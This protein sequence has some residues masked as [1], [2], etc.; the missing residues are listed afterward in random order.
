LKKIIL[1]YDRGEY[2]KVVTLARRTLFD[3]DYDK[4]EEIPIRT[5][6]AFS[7]VALERNEEAKDVFLQ[8]LSMAPDYYLDPDFVSPK[9]IQ[10]FREAQKEYFASLKEKEE[11]EPIPPPSW[12]DY[13][14]PGRYQKNYGNK[15]R[16]EFLRTGAVIS[17]GGLALSHLLYLYTHNLY[18]SKKDPEEVIRYYNYYNYS[19]KT[20]RFFF[21]L[22]LLFWM[23]NAFDLL[24][25]GK[26]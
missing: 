13:L 25:G 14:I 2:G 12:K 8:I 10:V 7:L 18:L 4:G 6:L 9:I 26:E 17:A 24:T 11:K 5:Y 1:L 21:D 22:V 20:R 16:G 3:R 15:K 23:Y 19:Y